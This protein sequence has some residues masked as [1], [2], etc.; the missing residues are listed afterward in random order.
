MRYRYNSACPC[1]RCRTHGYTGPAILITLGVL[2]LFD[3]MDMVHWMQF[4]YT[5]PAIL[6]VIGVVKLLEHGASVEGHIPREFGPP[7]WQPGNQGYPPQPYAGPPVPP[8]GPGYPT[9]PVVT[10]PPI[11]QAGFI[12]P[13]STVKGPDE[14]G[15]A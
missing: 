7:R 13:G 2:F 9:P 10:P 8:Q 4:N 5:W 15:G 6:I 3:Q 12:G 14:Q 1:P 11:P